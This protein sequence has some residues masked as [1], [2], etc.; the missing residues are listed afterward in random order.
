[1]LCY[2]RL[3][4]Q[5][6]FEPDSGP[7]EGN[8]TIELTGTNLGLTFTDIASITVAGR[9]CSLDGMETYYEPG[10]RYL[11]HQLS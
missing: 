5:Y 4:L 2:L 1:M 7:I 3:M 6:Q 8:T 9:Q 11:G 10:Q